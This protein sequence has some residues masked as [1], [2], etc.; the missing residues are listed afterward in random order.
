MR[1]ATQER[2]SAG[3]QPGG[4]GLAKRSAYGVCGLVGEVE[5]VGDF[6][7]GFHYFGT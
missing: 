2:E 4:S 6:S 1:C 7:L 5:D 3:Y